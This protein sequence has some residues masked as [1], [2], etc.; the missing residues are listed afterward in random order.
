MRGGVV[1]RGDIFACTR[2][3][4]DTWWPSLATARERRGGLSSRRGGGGAALLSVQ[5]LISSH[6]HSSLWHRA[7]VAAAA[8]AS[9]GGGRAHLPQIVAGVARACCARVAGMASRGVGVAGVRAAT[10]FCLPSLRAAT[11]LSLS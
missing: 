7:R 6:S 4:R 11:Y 5:R 3:S 2:V 1:P 8:A 9:R 10:L